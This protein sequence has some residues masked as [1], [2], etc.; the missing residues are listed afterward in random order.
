MP[1][2][3][4]RAAVESDVPA[5]LRLIRGLAAFEDLEHL[6][7]VDEPRLAQSLF[8]P[9]P[10]AEALVALTDD[11]PQAVGMAIFFPSYSTFLGRP[12]LYLEDLYVDEPHRGQGIGRALLK[13]VAAVAC[14]RGCP[15]L[16][17]AVM[18]WNKRAQKLY[19]AIGAKQHKEWTV[20][21]LTGEP[22]KR[23]ADS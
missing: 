11:Q 13:A 4:I 10:A 12:G 16:E 6:L 23:L 1:G 3:E 14:R 9:R 22:L 17:W 21:R 7:E 19:Q 5:L 15:R 18:D 2:F 8:G 20:C